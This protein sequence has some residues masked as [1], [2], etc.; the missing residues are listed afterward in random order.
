MSKTFDII[1]YD[2]CGNE[3]DEYFINESFRTGIQ[4]TLSD[5]QVSDN[6]LLVKVL[7]NKVTCHKVSNLEIDVDS[8]DEIIYV[9]E[10]STGK[11]L[12]ELRLVDSPREHGASPCPDESGRDIIALRLSLNALGKGG[13][14]ESRR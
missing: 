8:D 6:N 14:E 10:S 5:R 1:R 3:G 2:L 12:F 4:V 11:P 9:N 13:Y 7:A